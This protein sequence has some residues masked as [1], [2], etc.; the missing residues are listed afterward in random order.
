[1]N[2]APDRPSEINPL[3]ALLIKYPLMP[4][5][6]AEWDYYQSIRIEVDGKETIVKDIK[7]VH[8][9]P[10]RINAGDY[11]L[12]KDVNVS[13]ERV[14][15]NH[16]IIVIFLDG[17]EEDYTQK[18][19]TLIAPWDDR[20]LYDQNRTVIGYKAEYRGVPETWGEIEP[21]VLQLMSSSQPE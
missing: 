16:R 10:K 21:H 12:G 14:I 5:T 13:I 1:M 17:H 20:Y 19:F 18:E 11:V 8:N 6:R 3:P 2:F 15:P 4:R 9:T 7:V